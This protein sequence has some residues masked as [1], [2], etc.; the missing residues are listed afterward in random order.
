MKHLEKFFEY[1]RESREVSNDDLEDILIPF[2]DLGIKYDISEEET[3]TKGKFIGKKYKS[4]SFILKGLEMDPGF[5]VDDVIIDD[6]LW[7][8]FEEFITLKHKIEN[9]TDSGIGVKVDNISHIGYRFVIY[10]LT[11]KEESGDEL[12]LNTLFNSIQDK[13]HKCTSDFCYSMI[14]RLDMSKK[15]I[16]INADH[17][18]DRKWKIFTRGMDFSK[19]DTKFETT[20]D[21]FGDKTLITIKLKNNI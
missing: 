12:L 4:V 16:T 18:T 1:I 17:Y 14:N 7:E 3:L 2:T 8:F 15:E 20:P 21:R 13:Y 6:R 9:Y 11:G 10:F 5:Y 19:F